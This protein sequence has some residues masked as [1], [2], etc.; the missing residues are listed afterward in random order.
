MRDN[1]DNVKPIKF[2]WWIRF[3]L[4]FRKPYYGCDF[5]YDDPE[6]IVC[7]KELFGIYYITCHKLKD[8]ERRKDE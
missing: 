3:L 7:M 8:I 4:F 1:L 5:G 6:N 2:S